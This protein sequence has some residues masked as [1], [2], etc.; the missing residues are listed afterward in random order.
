MLFL[1]DFMLKCIDT[2]HGRNLKNRLQREREALMRKSRI[3][4]KDS[5]TPLDTFRTQAKQHQESILAVNNSLFSASQLF[6]EGADVK[7][8]QCD[9]A[10]DLLQGTQDLLQ[11]FH[12][13]LEV[14]AQ[15]PE[16]APHG[17]PLTTALR[18]TA[19]QA[20]NLARLVATFRSTRRASTPKR[21]QLQQEIYHLFESFTQSC[22]EIVQK[23]S[24]SLDRSYFQGKILADLHSIPNKPEARY[25]GKLIQLVKK[26]LD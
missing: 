17:Y 1:L 7:R 20:D 9:D 6:V 8:K 23:A 5:Q 18:Y 26:S 19:E 12:Q 24:T 21:M 2:C 25:A 11:V 16:I 3:R 13:L 4:S 22:E 10:L 15:L 14:A